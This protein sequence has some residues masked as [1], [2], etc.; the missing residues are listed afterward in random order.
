[1]SIHYRALSEY[2]PELAKVVVDVVD[3]GANPVE[4]D[5]PYK[6]L[7]AA[8]RARVVGFEPA[9]DAFARLEASKGPNETYLNRAV[10][11]GQEH[12]LHL[13]AASGMT[14]LL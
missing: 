9:P 2:V 6:P 13:C 7:L 4:G 11:D 1:M 3:I 5:P 12:T 14:S 10:G 8:G